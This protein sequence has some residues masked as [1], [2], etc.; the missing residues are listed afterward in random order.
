MTSPQQNCD[1][2]HT[3]DNGGIPP[4][5]LDAIENKLAARSPEEHIARQARLDAWQ[6]GRDAMTL[7]DHHLASGD[8]VAAHEAFTIA[9]R[10]EAADAAAM[11]HTVSA[12]QDALQDGAQPSAALS[13][14]RYWDEITNDRP[15]QDVLGQ[16]PQELIRQPDEVKAH[17]DELVV[18]AQCI[19]DE[20]RMRANNIVAAA[21][22]YA[23]I[24]LAE[25]LAAQAP[26]PVRGQVPTIKREYPETADRFRNCRRSNV[27]HAAVN[28][29]IYQS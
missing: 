29:P 3:F 12:L 19:L 13:P 20:A 6:L 8:F 2:L 25:A 26:S 14:P 10:Y 11:V 24:I 28:T 5:D 7:G 27:E 1:G 16:R 18:P 9:A 4:L 22:A 15:G 21:Q 23:E 17:L